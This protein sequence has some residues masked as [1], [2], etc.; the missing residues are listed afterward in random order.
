MSEATRLVLG[1]GLGGAA[2]RRDVEDG[3][4]QSAGTF[5]IR[6]DEALLIELGRNGSEQYGCKE[7][8]AACRETHNNAYFRLEATESFMV[9]SKNEGEGEKISGTR[10][11]TQAGVGFEI[12]RVWPSYFRIVF[13]TT[14]GVALAPVGEFNN[15]KWGGYASTAFYMG[16]PSVLFGLTLT[17]YFFT[18]EVDI[19]ATVGPRIDF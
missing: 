2:I 18:D 16:G 8:V 11:L 1:A 15:S 3:D 13:Q 14:G 19:S 6:I 7:N 5:A 17:P 4:F 9:G 10:I 12:H